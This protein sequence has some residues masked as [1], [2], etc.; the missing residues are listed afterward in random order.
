MTFYRVNSTFHILG[1]DWFHNKEATWCQTFGQHHDYWIIS[2]I[3]EIGPN[4]TFLILK[5]TFQIIQPN[6]YLNSC[7]MSSPRRC[8]QKL[9]KSYQTVFEKIDKITKFDPFLTLQTLTN[10]LQSNSIKSIFWQFI[11]T[12]LGKFHAQIEK[13]VIKQFLKIASKWKMNQIWPLWPSQ[14]RGEKSANFFSRWLAITINCDWSIIPSDWWFI[15]KL[16]N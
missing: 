4:L 5:M 14:S 15:L 2:I 3:M 13:K 16:V 10:D 12:L 1:Q 9:N 11:S 6:P 8:V 7:S